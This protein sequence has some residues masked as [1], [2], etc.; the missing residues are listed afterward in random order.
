[1]LVLVGGGVRCGKSAFAL[2]LAR[3]LGRRRVFVATAEAGD[4]E[5]AER[6]TRHAQDRGPDFRTVEAPRDVVRAV[7]AIEEADVV[8]LD[9]LTLWM[10]NLL[11]DGRSET[12]ILSEVD[13]LVLAFRE[14]PFH[15]VLVTNEVGMGVVPESPMGRAFRDV[16]G[17]MHQRFA[18]AADEIY[19]GALGTMIRLR[20][21]PVALMRGDR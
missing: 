10:S 3:R 2:A 7:R 9:C 12:E 13:S 21:E 5:M 19:F 4:G 20:P 14:Q 15:S 11:L 8:V 6:I 16:I 18:R 1:M 17:R